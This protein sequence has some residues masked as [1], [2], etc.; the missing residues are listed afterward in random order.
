[1][2]RIYLDYA[3]LTPIDPRVQREIEV[4]S[5]T[6]FANPSSIYKEGVAAK[7][8]LDAVRKNIADLIRAHADE[9]VFTSG[10]TE[11]NGL[12]LEGAGRAARRLGVEKPHIVTTEI[13]HSSIMEVIN[14]MEKNGVEVTRL[15]VDKNG[16]V[17]VDELRKAI[18][19]NTFLVSVMM[20]NNEIG[21][22]M[23]IREIAKAVRWSR[24]HVTKTKYPL[25]HTDAAQ[26]VLY[27]DLNME[28]LGADLMTLDAGKIYGPR[29]T[30]A[31][32]VKRGTAIEPI[33]YGGGQ[34]R[35]M[36]SGTENLPGIMGFAKAFGLAHQEREKESK[37]VL[38]LK[39]FFSE[40][41]KKLIPG[42][43]IHPGQSPHIL[44][45]SITGI[46]NE[47]LVLQL[48]AAGVA[49]S[50]KSSCL[51]DEDESYVLRAIGADSKTS[52]RFSFGRWTKKRDLTKTLKIMAKILA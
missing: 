18:K 43:K 45:V 20:V 36:R 29:G 50:T 15:P 4:F 47:F 42:I 52:V 49:V 11:A 35:G 21:S 23:P 26:A 32:Y 37:R 10:G 33:I 2:A 3:S 13:E 25:L 1:M 51:R 31:L 19:P 48:D 17:S 9:I 40:G 41:L 22:V 46:D 16:Q 38:E 12:A 14:M 44:N 24:E 8:S 30:G 34:E 5:A 27:N 28:Q 7:K 6:E 39:N